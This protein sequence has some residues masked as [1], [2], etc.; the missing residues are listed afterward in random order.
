M[1]SFSRVFIHKPI[2][3]RM[4]DQ[5]CRRT[6]TT[7]ILIQVCIVEQRRTMRQPWGGGGGGGGGEE[8]ENSLDHQRGQ[9]ASLDPVWPKDA[10]FPFEAASN[11]PTCRIFVHSSTSPKR[12]SPPP[13]RSQSSWFE[14]MKQKHACMCNSLRINLSPWSLEVRNARCWLNYIPCQHTLEI[15]L[16]RFA[17]PPPEEKTQILP[18]LYTS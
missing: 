15:V 13:H 14:H 18:R 9:C 6:P 12:P 4:M 2:G 8:T 10:R 3:Y 1:S 7:N 17:N 5:L 16:V 11:L